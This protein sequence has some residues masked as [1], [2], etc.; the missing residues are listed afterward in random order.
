MKGLDNPPT[1]RGS[2]TFRILNPS[3]NVRV[4]RPFMASKRSSEK[5]VIEATRK[6]I[7]EI[8]PLIREAV[9]RQ[10]FEAYME[11]LISRLGVERGSDQ[12]RFFEA[13]FWTAVAEVRKNKMQ[14]P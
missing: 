9:R 11:I 12:C 4:S 8:E 3:V 5:D 6:E 10:D 7:R 1:R 13:K 2:L 14:Q